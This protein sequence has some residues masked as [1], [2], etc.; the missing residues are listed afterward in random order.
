MVTLQSKRINQKLK[1]MRAPMASIR[2]NRSNEGVKGHRFTYQ[3][4]QIRTKAGEVFGLRESKSAHH[5]GKQL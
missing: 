3:Y 5:N 4:L 1:D 2:E